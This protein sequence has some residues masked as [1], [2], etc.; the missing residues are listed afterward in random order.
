MN[1][2][3]LLQKK[4]T[5]QSHIEAA[6]TVC[7]REMDAIKSYEAAI[8]EIGQQLAA[9]DKPKPKRVVMYVEADERVYGSA[10]VCHGG[11]LSFN[12][13]RRELALDDALVKRVAKAIRRKGSTW[14][15]LTECSRAAIKEMTGVEV[16]E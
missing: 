11:G 4:K 13:I 7:R 3:E 6:R 1:R 9:L 5:W 16:S 15:N 10:Y 8:A 14:G 12:C 2:E